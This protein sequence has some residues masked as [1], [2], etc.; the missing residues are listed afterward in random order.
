MSVEHSRALL[1]AQSVTGAP[2][3][4]LEQR[5]DNSVV[6]ISVD[7]GLPLSFLTAR[8][9]VS[10]L[11]RGLGTIVLFR[12]GLPGP[13]VAD[14]EEIAVAIDPARPLRVETA[15]PGESAVR[16][17]I[18]TSVTGR[19]VRVV[20]EGYGA[21]I[22][23][24]RTAVIRPSRP[25]NELGAVYAAALAAAEAFKHTARVL[26][27]RRVLHRHLRFCPVTLS[28]GLSAAP[29]LPS[30]LS[31]GLS[32]I[33]VGA[34]GTGIVLIL[35]ELPAE[36]KILAVDRQRFATENRGTYA[37][38][39]M[40]DVQ[41]KPWKTDIAQQALHRFDVEP[42]RGPVEDLP[43][44]VDAGQAPWFPTVLTALDSPEARREAQRLW[45]ERLIDA[46][47]GDTMLGICD[48]R[49]GVDP[50]LMCHFP[51]DRDQPSGAERIAQRLGLPSE[52]LGLGDT[53]LT[54]EHL[55][56]LTEKQRNFLRPHLGTSICGL[57]G[58][59]GLTGLDTDDFMPSVPFVS[60]QAACLAVGRLLAVA[61]GSGTIANFVQY[62]G[63]FG[64]QAATIDT[65]RQ[66][67]GCTCVTRS[68]SI[69]R[70]RQE[71][72][73]RQKPSLR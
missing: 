68:D 59:A 55:R 72:A 51:I 52:I 25:G 26:P 15:L 45:P 37:L 56:G 42:F 49:A 32:L 73:R 57:A 63:L 60:L 58:A 23:T 6:A 18:G 16:L 65:F 4:Q 64:P 29:P 24:A 46:A 62:D 30:V 19:A 48:Y 21:H 1:L 36:G 33:G 38:G 50:C 31:L 5:L 3:G 71:R 2:S 28:A 11:R 27:A 69:G 44:A 53:P 7:P 43:A 39:G 61:L 9:L 66:R 12:E 47:T 70:V 13:M 20:P 54:E 35:S 40:A 41:A 34:I 17:H 14:L 8:V 67:P 10:T 22:A